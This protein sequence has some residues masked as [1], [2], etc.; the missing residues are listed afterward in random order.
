MVRVADIDGGK[1]ELHERHEISK[2]HTRNNDLVNS[3]A[4]RAAP[5]C[6]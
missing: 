5:S 2:R 6:T 1:F 4:K 3:S